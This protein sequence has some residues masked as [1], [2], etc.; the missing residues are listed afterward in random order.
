MNEKYEK[1]IFKSTW[2]DIKQHAERDGLILVDPEIQLAHA[3][4]MIVENQTEVINQWIND[5]KIGKPTQDQLDSWNSDDQKPFLFF[6]AQ[7]YVLIQ[8]LSLQ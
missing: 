8:V 6:I 2:T 7:P 4:H 1:Q 5:G 3:A